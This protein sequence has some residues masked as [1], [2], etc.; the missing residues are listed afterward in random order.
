ML[1]ATAQAANIQPST[2]TSC[3]ISL[4]GEITEN[5]GSEFLSVVESLGMT[6]AEGDFEANNPE[7]SALC[8]NSSGGHFFAGQFIAHIVHKNGIPTR[9][10]NDDECYSACAMIFMA[11]RSLGAEWDTPFRALEP[12]ARVGFHAPYANFDENFELSGAQLNSIVAFQNAMVSE[13]VRSGTYKSIFSHRPAFSPMLLAEMLAADRD[14][15]VLI[16]TIGDVERW[17]VTLENHVTVKEF[18]KRAIANACENFQ[19]WQLDTEPK[20]TSGS[21]LPEIKI[22]TKNNEYGEEVQMLR[23]NTGGMAERYCL[24]SWDV[25]NPEFFQICSVDDFSGVHFGRCPDAPFRVPVYYALPS[26][27]PIFMLANDN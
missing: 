13:I 8:L 26:R 21:Y 9:V 3:A 22:V 18:D 25:K 24:V 7:T 5:D 27:T 2:H 1:S 4:S 19:S 11:G 23:V 20:L 6:Y 10:L 16:E 14:E 17:G 12:K 15:L